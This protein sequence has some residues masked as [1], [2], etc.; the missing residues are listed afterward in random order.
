MVLV[1]MAH[2]ACACTLNQ[3]IATNFV[4]QWKKIIFNPDGASPHRN[5]MLLTARED[6]YAWGDVDGREA[7]KQNH[8]GFI[9]LQTLSPSPARSKAIENYIFIS[10]LYTC[11][12]MTF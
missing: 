10:L 5:E 9:W 6:F 12:L 4:S 11:E 1:Y 7:S 3:S 8:A 2:F